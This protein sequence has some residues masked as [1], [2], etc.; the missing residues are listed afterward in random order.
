[1][2]INDLHF[3]W[4]INLCEICVEQKLNP[5]RHL[6]QT[7][8]N[9]EPIEIKSNRFWLWFIT[10]IHRTVY[11]CCIVEC[12]STLKLDQVTAMIWLS[13]TMMRIPCDRVYDMSRNLGRHNHSIFFLIH[14]SWKNPSDFQK[15]PENT[16]RNLQPKI[17]AMFGQSFYFFTFWHLFQKIS[18]FT[19]FQKISG[20]QKRWLEK[21]GRSGEECLG[22]K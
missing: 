17:Q 5:K 7:N 14:L 20:F 19:H 1:M 16:S 21:A 2:K 6:L 22:Q 4:W 12:S 3:I 13:D 11:A 10:S 18:T 15:N 9:S 8:T